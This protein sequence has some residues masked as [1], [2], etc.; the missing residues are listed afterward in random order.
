MKG[1][2]GGQAHITGIGGHHAQATPA[3]HAHMLLNEQKQS[4]VQ[5]AEHGVWQM[6]AG[7]GQGLG[8][9]GAHQFGLI[10]QHGEEA[11]QFGLHAGSTAAEKPTDQRDEIE[12]ATPA[13]MPWISQMARA[14]LV[15]MQ[16]RDELAQYRD[17]P[18]S[19]REIVRMTTRR[20]LPAQTRVYK[21][22]RLKLRGLG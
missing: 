6:L 10:A 7:F 22:L 2:T 19:Y 15:R 18:S 12:H 8:A 4:P 13:E 21:D 14:Q 16:V 9:D 11:I 3:R 1:V 20:I 5:I 17:N